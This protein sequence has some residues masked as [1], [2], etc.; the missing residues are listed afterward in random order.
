MI[1]WSIALPSFLTALVEWVEAFTIVLGVSFSIGWRSAIGAS[2]AVL[3]TLAALTLVAS[4]LLT[5]G[6]LAQKLPE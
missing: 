4:R 5:A 6:R 2:L 1:D 3:A